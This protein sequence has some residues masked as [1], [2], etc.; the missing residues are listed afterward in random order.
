ML[1]MRPLV[2]AVLIEEIGSL[3]QTEIHGVA[4]IDLVAVL[5]PACQ[6][7]PMTTVGKK[8]RCPIQGVRPV[9]QR[10]PIR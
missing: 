6:G 7:K 4:P 3:D 2:Q 10:E 9:Q 5:M 1:E 8:R